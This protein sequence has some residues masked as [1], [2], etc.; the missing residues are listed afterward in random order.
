MANYYLDIETTGL[1]PKHDRIITIQY[2]KLERG[3][4]RASGPL[5][6]LREWDSGEA[7]MLREFIEDSRIT[8]SYPFAFVPVGYNLHFEHNFLSE[9]CRQHGLPRVDILGRPHLDLRVC[10]IIMNGGEFKDSG[11]DKLTRKPHDGS[12]IPAWYRDGKHEEIID[13]VQKEA[14]EFVRFACWLH[15]ELPDSL[16]RFRAQPGSQ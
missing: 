16:H 12:I 9:K 7:R 1:D 14:G 4:A 2:Q 6:I 13:Y 10:G 15:K 11:L 8:D 5:K 3:S